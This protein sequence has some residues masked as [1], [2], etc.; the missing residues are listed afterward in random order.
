MKSLFEIEWHGDAAEKHFRR[1]RPFVTQ[2]PW[3]TIDKSRHTPQVLEQARTVWSSIAMSEYH[4]AAAFADVLGA[5]LAAKAPLD[6]AGMAG[7]FVADELMHVELASRIAM[8]LGGAAPVLVDFE[9]MGIK[10]SAPGLDA[11]ARA[12]DLV[13]RAGCVAETCSGAIAVE[14]SRRIVEQPL[15]RAV[16]EQIARDE[17]RHMR[18]GWLYMEWA[19]EQMEDG[20]RSRLG[21]VV[22]DELAEMAPTWKRS[23][24]APHG[25]DYGWLDGDAFRAQM[26][27]TI[28]DDIVA[29]LEK[30][31]IPIDRDRVRTLL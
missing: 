9:E 27:T 19:A 1:I 12:N 24:H 31:G 11:F 6:I 4:A 15:I 28:L 2:L 22:V 29:P 7:D 3:G 21:R 23:H 26:S 10:P 14:T 17:A 20:E 18:F 13:V 16:A 25:R 30:L 8:E 5:V